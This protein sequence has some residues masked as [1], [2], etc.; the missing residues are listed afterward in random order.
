MSDSN[1]TDNFNSNAIVA[2]DRAETEPCERGTTGCSVVHSVA[3]M[4]SC[5]E[6]W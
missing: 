5:C 2:W 3:G 1:G 4:A 6:T